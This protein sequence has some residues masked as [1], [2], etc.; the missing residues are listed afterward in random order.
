MTLFHLNLHEHGTILEDEEGHRLADLNAAHSAAV[1]SA[2][3]IMSEEVSNG[4]LCLS[5]CIVITNAGHSE[6]GRVEFRDAI[7]LSGV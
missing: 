1:V 7:A 6:V 3:A 4:A 5:C 2:R